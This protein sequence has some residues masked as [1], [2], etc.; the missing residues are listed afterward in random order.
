[1]N[2]SNH[3]CTNRIR[4]NTAE[5]EA[6][7]ADLER[8]GGQESDPERVVQLLE[9]KDHMHSVLAKLTTRERAVLHCRYW[10]NMTLDETAVETK[11]YSMSGNP[12]A[13]DRIRQI[14][15]KALRKLKHP[16]RE[17]RQYIEGVSA[18]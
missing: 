18:L 5:V 6:S 9:F 7:A 13:R 14:E 3:E 15:C 16:S 17:L 4:T 2:K 10:Q 1:M 11:R 12:V 8:L